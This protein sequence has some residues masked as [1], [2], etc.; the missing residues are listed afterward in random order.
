MQRPRVCKTRGRHR[1]TVAERSEDKPTGDPK[2]RKRTW[3]GDTIR[4]LLTAEQYAGGAARLRYRGGVADRYADAEA[5]LRALLV[6]IARAD[7]SPLASMARIAN[8]YLDQFRGMRIGIDGSVVSNREGGWIDI[9]CFGGSATHS[10]TSEAVHM[11][12]ALGRRAMNAPSPAVGRDALAAELA[13]DFLY[14]LA[15]ATRLKRH[16]EQRVPNARVGIMSWRA[17][18]VPVVPGEAIKVPTDN[19]N[20]KAVVG[21]FSKILWTRGDAQNIGEALVRAGLVALGYTKRSAASV[22]E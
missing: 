14:M 7:P 8:R 21:A 22:F 17:Q 20:R 13:E 6:A 12:T 19:D 15:G 5:I 18:D 9:L 3:R 4:A 16:L 10:R 2:K 1:W 11:A